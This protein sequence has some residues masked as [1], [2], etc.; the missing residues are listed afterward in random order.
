LNHGFA[1]VMQ[2]IAGRIKSQ[3]QDLSI[4]PFQQEMN[5]FIGGTFQA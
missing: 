1:R 3:N 2:D 5:D 4:T